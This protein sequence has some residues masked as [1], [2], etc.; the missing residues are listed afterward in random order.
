MSEYEY[1]SESESQE[2]E[3]EEEK[4]FTGDWYADGAIMQEILD[5]I[6][7]YS[8]SERKRML[9]TPNKSGSML[10]GT[11]WRSFLKYDKDGNKVF[12]EKCSSTG[13]SKTK[14]YSDY[15]ELK[16]IFKEY[17]NH[18]FPNF[19]YNQVQMNKDFACPPH[20]DSTN[21]GT[22][23]LVAFGDYLDGET[24]TYNEQLRK[25][26]KYDAREKPIVFDGSRVLHWVK[27]PRRF[28]TR[29]S[30]VFFNNKSSVKKVTNV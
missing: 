19:E 23:T 10:Y 15:P 20:F 3:E 14:I 11:T 25:I 28:G 16:E 4:M 6:E 2:E 24:C 26:E 7:F 29:Y 27:P 5:Q 13:Q 18:H 8:G 12:R 9:Y 21:T 30:L 17:A 1:E 22:S